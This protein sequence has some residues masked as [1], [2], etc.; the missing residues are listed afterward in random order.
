M[1][2]SEHSRWWALKI[3]IKGG[4]FVMILFKPKEDIFSL[5]SVLVSYN[6]LTFD[7]DSTAFAKESAFV[8]IALRRELT[9]LAAILLMVP[10]I[11]STGP[12][13]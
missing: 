4:A 7:N 12:F 11:P 13:P 2:S 8:I 3:P 9:A 1:V 6:T 10:P 5:M